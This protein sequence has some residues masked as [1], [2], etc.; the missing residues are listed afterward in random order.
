LENMP[1]PQSSKDCDRIKILL[2][3]CGRRRSAFF[4]T[5]GGCGPHGGWHFGA[6]SDLGKSFLVAAGKFLE[7][8][9]KPFSADVFIVIRGDEVYFNR[10]LTAAIAHDGASK[11]CDAG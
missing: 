2:A 8:T 3:G 10:A 9:D 4:G 5:V 11:R 6:I 7:Q 1:P